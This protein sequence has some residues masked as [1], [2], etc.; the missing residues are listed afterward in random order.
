MLRI[1]NRKEQLMKRFRCFSIEIAIFWTIILIYTLISKHYVKYYY[2]HLSQVAASIPKEYMNSEESERYKTDNEFLIQSKENTYM[3]YGIE[4]SN[5][6]ESSLITFLDEED[7]K[8]LKSANSFSQ[9][10]EGI[11]DGIGFLWGDVETG[12]IQ[13]PSDT[14][15]Y[16]SSIEESH[17]ED[18]QVY[19]MFYIKG[20]L[21]YMGIYVTDEEHSLSE[22]QK[23]HI[24]LYTR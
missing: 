16:F 8:K 5:V 19:I 1:K 18:Y 14:T 23:R 3:I 20:D 2:I 7:L 9:I 11:Q 6:D 4:L 24:R 12:S 21:K 17:D 10:L 15:Y 22:K 13:N